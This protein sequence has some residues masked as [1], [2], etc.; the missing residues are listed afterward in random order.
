MITPFA[1]TAVCAK[2]RAM[3]GGMLKPE[4]YAALAGMHSVTEVAAYLTDQT[5]Y[6]TEFEAVNLNLANRHEVERLLSENLYHTVEKISSFSSG[7]IR[8]SIQALMKKF[9]MN[10]VLRAVDRIYKK[11]PIPEGSKVPADAAPFSPRIDMAALVRARTF[12]EALSALRESEYRKALESSLS[13]DTLNYALFEV[14]L[15]DAYY[16]GLYQL[17]ERESAGRAANIVGVIADIINLS[18]IYRF[19]VHFQIEPEQIYPYLM[20]LYGRLKKKDY[21]RLCALGPEEFV[22]A[23]RNSVYGGALTA[24]TE[25]AN[26]A[27]SDRLLVKYYKKLFLQPEPSLAVVFAFFSLKELEVQNLVHVTEGV[28]YGIE[29]DRILE[30]IVQI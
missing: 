17:F 24:G 12:D 27:D 7:P 14:L 25:D 22:A 30:N 6:A 11:Q 1:Y 10:F 13:G 23:Y 3:Y 16:E 28:R 29:G 21:V 18:R 26:F 20:N 5:S 8:D 15:Y 2:C 9:D 4:Q 19:K